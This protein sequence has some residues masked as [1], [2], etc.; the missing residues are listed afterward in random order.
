MARGIL[1]IISF[2]WLG[3]SPAFAQLSPD[4]ETLDAAA[5]EAYRE[6]EY[7]L[8]AERWSAALELEALASSPGER[9]RV[10]Y[11][12]GNCALRQDRPL[13]AVAH[14]HAAAKLRPRDPA[15]LANLDYARSEADL[16]PV[17]R[18]S[19]LRS[20]T[21]AE[22]ERLVMAL[23]LLLFL[24]LLGEAV[25]GGAFRHAA[26][27][28]GVLLLLSLVP[29]LGQLRSVDQ[30]EAM[31]VQRNG[32]PLRSEPRSGSKTLVRLDAGTEHSVRDELPEWIALETGDGVEG[33]VPAR[34][35]L[36]TTR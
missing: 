8:A 19:L 21:L 20:L 35:V 27:V 12:L 5:V 14:Y 15:I 11:N 25:L 7:G 28:L 13:E 6:L 30:R 24:S 33:W 36:R 10:L 16:D 3:L 31:V 17:G 23:T 18:P 32:T 9:A 22:A 4:L 29:W 26:V 2:V 1:F 34:H